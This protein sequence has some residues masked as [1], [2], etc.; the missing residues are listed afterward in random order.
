[1]LYKS[2]S[3]HF[4]T[5]NNSLLKRIRILSPQ[6]ASQIAAG[7]V[8]ERPA[9]VVKE[10]LENSL[11]ADAKVIEITIQKGGAELIS[12]CDDGMG[13][14]KDDLL[15]T[16]TP[17]ATSKIQT[18]NDLH[19]IN[20][21]GFRGEALASISSVSQFS[22]I[23]K[24]RKSD[25]AWQLTQ[26]AEQ[27]KLIPAAHPQGTTIEVRNLFYNIPVRRRFLKAERT[28]FQ[29]IEEIVKR[30]A[31]S[32][33]DVSFIL[34]HNQRQIMRVQPANDEYSIKQRLQ[35]L[36]GKQFIQTALQFDT[37]RVGLRLHGWILP[38]DTAR[39][40]ADQQ[41]FFVNNRIVKDKLLNHAVRAAYAETLPEG[42][43]PAYVLYLECDP[44]EVDVNV[45]PTKQE[46]R[47]Q[48][49]R[50]VHDF[51]QY[52]L[53]RLLQPIKNDEVQLH[54]NAE[55][56]AL[57][58]H[59]HYDVADNKLK[60]RDMT[61]Q[62][63]V[64]L[65][66]AIGL[67]AQRFIIATIEND[68]VLVDRMQAYGWLL[69]QRLEHTLQTAALRAQPLLLP[70]TVTVNADQLKTILNQEAL[71]QRFAINIVQAAPNAVM[72]KALPEC[73][74]DIKAEKLVQALPTLHTTEETLAWIV[75]ASVPAK[76]NTIAEMN[77]FLQDLASFPLQTLRKEKLV[78]R[79]SLIE[80][81]KLFK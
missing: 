8:V 9:S 81:E 37:E 67:V 79:F 44:I 47:F 48:Q 14:C 4:I 52:S 29:H 19:D 36:L 58:S 56:T 39:A 26:V 45:H 1:M 35:K 11:D 69:R 72:L 33:Y 74:R 5:M 63:T 71:W 61:E 38:S 77:L 64:K 28:E 10:L 40:H 22:L 32:A 17:H 20:S 13:I 65:A 54:H 21:L 34:H 51:V 57:V 18:I 2:Q 66:D 31:L 50:L 42:R 46:V 62:S 30:M 70:A 23:S 41:Y 68:L 25:A 55:S 24:H 53:Q 16:I 6:V 80:L 73:L 76:I 60:Y 43:Y 15:L 78:K 3:Y 75:S 49:M 7:E 59:S 27:T 12:I